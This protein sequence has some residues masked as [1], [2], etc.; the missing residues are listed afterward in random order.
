MT[1]CHIWLNGT[2]LCR[3]LVKSKPK[4][5]FVTFE[6]CIFSFFFGGAKTIQVPVQRRS[7]FWIWSVKL[8]KFNTLRQTLSS[9]HLAATQFYVSAQV[10]LICEK[11]QSFSIFLI[12]ISWQPLVH[13]HFQRPKLFLLLGHDRLS[14]YLLDGTSFCR[15]CEDG[16][17]VKSNP[18][19]V[20]FD[21]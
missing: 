16:V 7:R 10:H 20:T 8:R 14:S 11:Q 4:F 6:I 13:S 12:V 18:K 2:G 5:L 17:R 1:S 9:I 19:F 3:L 21:M 15:F